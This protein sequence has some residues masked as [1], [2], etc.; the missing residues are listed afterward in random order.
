MINVKTDRWELSIAFALSVVFVIP[1][2]IHNVYFV[3]DWLRADL[4]T[5][6]WE[7]N[8]RPLSSI[9]MSILSL[10]PLKYFGDGVLFDTF[11]FNLFA[12]SAIMV[13]SG[14]I[15]C[16]VILIKNSAIRVMIMIAPVVNPYWIGNIAFRFDSLVMSMAFLFAVLTVFFI[17]SGGVFNLFLSL[18]SATAMLCLYQAA[19]NVIVS[20]ALIVEIAKLRSNGY[21]IL[22]ESAIL[23][24]LAIIGIS[25][26]LYKLF[27]YK[28]LDI[29]DY[30]K[31]SGELI[32]I[33]A[34]SFGLIM[35][36]IQSLSKAIFVL[37]GNMIA[38]LILMII[39]VS[40]CLSLKIHADTVV[41]R[42]VFF[43]TPFAIF[44]LSFGFLS[45]LKNPAISS[46]VF[47]SFCFVII[48]FMFCSDRNGDK[49]YLLAVPFF[50]A[51]IS[52][53][54][55]ASNTMS[56]VQRY[57]RFIAERIVNKL[58]DVGYQND[59]GVYIS[60]R[61][62][63]PYLVSRVSKD[64]PIVSELSVSAFAN[65]R[66]K[67][68]LLRQYGIYSPTPEVSVAIR[69]TNSCSNE[70]AAIHDRLMSICRS[71]NGYSIILN[72]S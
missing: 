20:F 30:T 51:S 52:L 16:N 21:S 47:I 24:S 5:T 31:T 38:F 17:V 37:P 15:I 23:K 57:D 68:S 35:E 29:S 1:F 63:A 58:Y 4:G 28:H 56:D 43:A 14:Y 61:P 36:N 67:Y 66:F 53:S 42:I 71:K 62:S 49:L 41:K 9:I 22:R 46:R 34:R 65:T 45:L 11:P 7:G 10:S 3:D 39:I 54:F 25:Y 72:R 40:I 13:L 50:I 26:V 32:G 70:K 6:S 44:A 64:I 55:I 60:G 59:R 2:A 69:E 33:D 18:I 27:I 19:I 8:G 48:Y 12:S